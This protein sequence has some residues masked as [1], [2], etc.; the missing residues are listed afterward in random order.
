MKNLPYKWMVFI[1][2][3]I[4]LLII[5]LKIYF[6]DLSYISLKLKTSLKLLLNFIVFRKIHLEKKLFK[7]ILLEYIYGKLNILCLLH[8]RVFQQIRT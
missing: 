3:Q 8:A 6:H 7:K 1:Y 4:H 5:Y 2:E